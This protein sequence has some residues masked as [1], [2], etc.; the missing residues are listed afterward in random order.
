MTVT[1]KG[2]NLHDVVQALRLEKCSAICEFHPELFDRNPSYLCSKNWQY[3][4][5]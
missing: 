4:I 1:V 5:A 3:L 2:K